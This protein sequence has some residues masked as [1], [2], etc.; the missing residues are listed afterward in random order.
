MSSRGKHAHRVLIFGARDW[1]DK[2][3]IME[4]IDEL[5]GK[6]GKNR[7]IIIQG[8]APGADMLAEVCSDERGIHSARVKALW[9]TRHRGAGPQRNDAMLLLEPHEAYGFHEDIKN[10][11]RGSKGMY[12]K[13]LTAGI[14]VEIRGEV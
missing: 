13:C 2:N 14:K 11:S 5:I 12:K 8:G 9:E 10:K 4:L 1:S 6:Y 3:M 7:L